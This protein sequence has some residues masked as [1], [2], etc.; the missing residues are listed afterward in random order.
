MER[1]IFEDGMRDLSIA[2][3]VEVTGKI[4][5]YWEH[6]QDLSDEDFL[7]AVKNIIQNSH[8]FPT[9]SDIRTLQG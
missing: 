2:Y 6:L 4:D 8:K 5:V 1:K 3:D 9:I 7:T